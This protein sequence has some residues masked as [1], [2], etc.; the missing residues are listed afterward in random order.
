M[1][2]RR[3]GRPQDPD[4][5]RAQ[6]K[7]AETM[8]TAALL[9]KATAILTLALA[10]TWV[11]RGSRAA[12]RHVLLAAGFAMLLLLP[13]VST[14]SPVVTVTVPAALQNTIEPFHDAI[15][16]DPSAPS[17]APPPSSPALEEA[18]PRWN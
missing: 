15:L 11:T 17:K 18:Q 14:I 5:S 10:A 8:M 1:E 3:T 7:E 6:G 13:A 4:R 2:R 16:I 12:L 9:L